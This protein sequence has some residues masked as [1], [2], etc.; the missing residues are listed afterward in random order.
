MNEML[1]LF[2]L[3]L[4]VAWPAI[5]FGIVIWAVIFIVVRQNVRRAIA[6]FQAMTPA[7]QFAVLQALAAQQRWQQ[8]NR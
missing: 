7:Q 3:G 5:L 1:G 6:Q 8:M 4:Y 2:L